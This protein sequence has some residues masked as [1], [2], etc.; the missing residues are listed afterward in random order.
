MG[1]A[2]LC[3]EGEEAMKEGY[4]SAVS[5]SP[6]MRPEESADSHCRKR[7]LHLSHGH[8]HGQVANAENVT[9][10]IVVRKQ[11][12]L[13]VVGDSTMKVKNPRSVPLD[14]GP[15]VVLMTIRVTP[16]QNDYAIGLWRHIPLRGTT[17]SRT[18]IWKLDT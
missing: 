17:I 13:P 9:S 15:S 7:G 6:S 10:S 5:Q 14:F 2:I 11:Q 12:P 16:H 18:E 4:L 8:G 1:N 3:T